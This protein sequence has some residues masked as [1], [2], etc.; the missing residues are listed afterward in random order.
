MKYFIHIIVNVNKICLLFLPFDFNVFFC[1]WW[2]KYLQKNPLKKIPSKK[3]VE[4]NTFKKSGEKQSFL[5]N[6]ENL[7]PRKKTP[8]VNP[9][10]KLFLNSYKVHHLHL[11]YC[12]VTL[13]AKLQ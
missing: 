1:I 7:I 13:L 8:R 3:S 6:E 11:L 10:K 9:I 12:I 5:F 2:K 4:K